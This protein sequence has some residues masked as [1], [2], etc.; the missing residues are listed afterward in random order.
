DQRVRISHGIRLAVPGLRSAAGAHQL[1]EC[2]FQRV[3]RLRAVDPPGA[4][5]DEGGYGVDAQLGRRLALQTY[6]IAGDIGGE[7][8]VDPVEIEPDQTGTRSESVVVG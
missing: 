5:E 2:A 8:V 6:L 3:L 1:G 4:V 7:Y